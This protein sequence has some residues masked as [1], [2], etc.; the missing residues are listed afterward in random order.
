[1]GWG[2]RTSP[3][4]YADR[5]QPPG[6]QTL[7]PP[8]PGPRATSYRVLAI[9]LD[10]AALDE[11]GLGLVRSS[12]AIR[13]L[14]IAALRAAA[15]AETYGGAWLVA[16]DRSYCHVDA[17]GVVTPQTGWATAAARAITNRRTSPS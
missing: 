3:L 5:V 8:S 7:L 10:A 4:P 2:E 17:A 15:A 1:M 13:D 14:S 9:D 6:Q 16:A 12:E 11:L